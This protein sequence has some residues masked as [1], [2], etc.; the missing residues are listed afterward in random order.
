LGKEGLKITVGPSNILMRPQVFATDSKVRYVLSGT[1]DNVNKS[2]STFDLD[3]GRIFPAAYNKVSTYWSFRESGD[4]F[5][6]VPVDNNAFAIA[7]FDNGATVSAIGTFSV[8][9]LFLA[10]DVTITFPVTQVGTVD[11]GTISSGWVDDTFSLA[12]LNDNLVIP[13]PSRVSA[14]YDDNTTLSPLLNSD[15]AIVKGAVVTAR[16]YAIAEGGGTEA[17]WISVVP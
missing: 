4:P 3:T 17:F 10:D 14:R 5:R 6:S 11:S 2:S 8:G 16:G 9:G 15:A 12:L 1:V 7:A 13:Q